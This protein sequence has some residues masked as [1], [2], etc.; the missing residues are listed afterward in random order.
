MDITAANRGDQPFTFELAGTEHT[1]AAGA[2]RTV[3]VPVAED[4]AYD[5]TITGPAGFTRTFTGVLDCA[6]SGS[7][8]DRESEGDAGND[9]GT[10]S[11]QQSV[12]A[13]TGSVTSGL[14]GDLAE[15]GGSSATPMLAAVAIG[16]LVVG[17]G[18][19]FVLRRQKPHT[20]GE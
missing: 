2:T 9:I 4:Q 10:Q 3:T 17:G 15:T 18:A 7:V 16:L 5:F 6:T 8:L 1:I 13:T 11:A 19:V 14:E 12:P 20:D